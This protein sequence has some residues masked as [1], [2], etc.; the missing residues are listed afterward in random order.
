M[1][2]KVVIITGATSGIGKAL[3]FEF[4][5]KGSLVVITGRR[6]EE[7]Q[8]IAD[9]LIKNGVEVLPLQG[10]HQTLW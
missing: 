9:E 2:N 6:G 8:A 10:D 7:L 3:A 1:K 5:K 4:G